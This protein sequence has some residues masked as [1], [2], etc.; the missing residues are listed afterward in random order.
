MEVGGGCGGVVLGRMEGVGGWVEG[1]SSCGP[2]A[3]SEPSGEKAT[4]L[5]ESSC[6]SEH[7][8]LPLSACNGYAR[9]MRRWR[10]TQLLRRMSF[11][12]GSSVPLSASTT[13]TSPS[14]PVNKA[15]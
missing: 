4:Q 11:C 8:F 15:V 1:G 14:S 6:A 9:T 13:I 2:L 3:S 12:D 10:A 7:T 5:T